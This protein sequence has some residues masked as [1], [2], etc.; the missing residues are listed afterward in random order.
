MFAWLENRNREEESKRLSREL[1]RETDNQEI[2]KMLAERVVKLMPILAQAGFTPV[3]YHTV[4]LD[5]R[6]GEMYAVAPDKSIV[7]VKFWPKGAL[8]IGKI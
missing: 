5:D 3:H 7:F 1:K 8:T 4:D 6:C 2:K